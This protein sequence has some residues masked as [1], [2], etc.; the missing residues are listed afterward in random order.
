MNGVMKLKHW[1][2]FLILSVSVIVSE[3]IAYAEIGIGNLDW[4]KSATL[5]REIGMVVCFSWLLLLGLS[6]NRVKENPHKFRSG[7]F[8]IFIVAEIFGYTDVN[9]DALL[10]D[11]NP[12][13][14]FLSLLFALMTFIGL[15]YVFYNIPKSLKSIE[16][17]EQVKFKDCIIDLL[18]IIFFP[19][20]IWV[21][22][23]R[24]NRIYQV[25]TE[26]AYE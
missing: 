23:P 17:G 21:L 20:G 15:L 22:Q 25:E 6:L 10:G 1:Q 2:L 18:L 8:V 9:L 12:I 13:P 5:F 7:L 16:V 26:M 24:L 11:R 14:E 19:I 4:I 3:T